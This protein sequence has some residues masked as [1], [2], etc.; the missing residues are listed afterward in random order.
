LRR[1]ILTGKPEKGGD[2][3]KNDRRD[4]CMLARLDRAGE[5]TPVYVPFAENEAIGDLT[6][7]REDAKIDEKNPGSGCWPFCFEADSNIRAKRHGAKPKCAGCRISKCPIPFSRLYCRSI[8]IPSPNA[9]CS[10]ANLK[11][12]P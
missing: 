5:L 8:S 4:A 9:A 3:I 1:V 6:R 11:L 10:F 2:R 12:T 7:A